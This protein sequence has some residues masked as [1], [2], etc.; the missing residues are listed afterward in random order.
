MKKVVTII[1]IG[2]ALFFGYKGVKILLD[3]AADAKR[4]E[5]AKQGWYLE[6]LT[7]S[8]NVRKE[9]S[10][11][12]D[13]IGEIYKGEIYEIADYSLE[14][15]CS[16]SSTATCRYWYEIVLKDGSY[17]WVANTKNGEYLKDYGGHIDVATPTL[18]CINYNKEKQTCGPIHVLSLEDL[19]NMDFNKFY[20]VWDDRDDWVFTYEVFHELDKQLNKD[21]YWLQLTVTDK[22]GKYKK[23]VALVEFEQRPAESEVKSFGELKR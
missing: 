20:N 4:V 5:K 1:L 9:A 18:E 23:T 22:S 12:S 21:Q 2:I 8:I 14:G 13:K 16:G 6:V 3:K 17:A 11:T 19:K 10:R 15:N 7:P